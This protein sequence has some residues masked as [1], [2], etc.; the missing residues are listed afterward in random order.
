MRNVLFILAVSLFSVLS[1][2]NAQGFQLKV[3]IKG[4]NDD[5]LYLAHY[6]ADK[7]Y[8]DDTLRKGKG[9]WFVLEVDSMLTGGLY[10]IA[11]E[12][13]NRYFE[14]LMNNEPRISFETIADDPV[15][16]MQIKGSSENLAFFRYIHYLGKKQKEIEPYQKIFKRTEGL[17]PDSASLAKAW[18]QKINDEV[19][20]YIKEFI[21]SHEGMF[22]ADFV[23]ASQEPEIPD[24]PLLP[25]GRPDSLFAYKYYKAHY[26]DNLPLNDA[27]LLRTPFYH[28]RVNT[29]FT[30]MVL[31][32]PD[33]IIAE[34][35]RLIP[36][37]S[38][39]ADTYRYM[40]WFLT[41][42]TERSEIMGMDAAFVYMVENYYA[43]GEMDYWINNTVKE[44]LIKKAKKLK[45][46]L[47]GQTA[48]E[49]IMLDTF[50]QPISLHQLK[51]RYTILLFWD[52]TCG[53][54][55]KEIPMLKDFMT[56]KGKQ[57]DIEVFAVCSDTNMREMKNYIRQ[58]DMDWINVNGPRA[59]TANYHDLYDIYSTPII[60]LLDE[61]KTILAKRLTVEQIESFIEHHSRSESGGVLQMKQEYRNNK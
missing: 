7:Q 50:M 54:C 11:G 48:P 42:F 52:P 22:A 51:A 56:R 43:S 47:I 3:K 23:K 18:M 19:M 36:I 4:A 20:S 15:N 1:E 30:K 16:N 8:M 46:I 44:N 6:F 28:Q 9:E 34:A 40:I 12:K 10:I 38:Q 25:N 41:N 5:F 57:Y 53:H 49:L 58:Y 14:F 24:P 27:R 59:Y 39:S 29:Y 37:A 61:K 13:K 45:P 2:V 26:F 31:Q 32:H 35:K 17:Y 60:Y 55:K 21:E 33:S